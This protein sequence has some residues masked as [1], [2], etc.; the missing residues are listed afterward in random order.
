MVPLI[1]LPT[2]TPAVVAGLPGSH[3]LAR[4]LVA[5]GITTGARIQVL[6]NWGSGPVIVE[7]RGA[8]LALGRGQAARILVRPVPE[9]QWDEGECVDPVD[10]PTPPA[11]T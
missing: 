1:K 8:R 3:G 4:R 6:H 9:E 11:H 5:L 10:Q 7:V 2:C